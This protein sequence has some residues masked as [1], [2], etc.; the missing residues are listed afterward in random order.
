MD[1]TASDTMSGTRHSRAPIGHPDATPPRDEKKLEKQVGFSRGV[2]MDHP[3]LHPLW[4]QKL[5]AN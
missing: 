1:T 4:N 2:A 3:E 5:Y